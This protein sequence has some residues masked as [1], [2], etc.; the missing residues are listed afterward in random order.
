MAVNFILLAACCYLLR[1]CFIAAKS[2]L[3][4][5]SPVRVSI[6]LYMICGDLQIIFGFFAVSTIAISVAASKLYQEFPLSAH[7]PPRYFMRACLATF[8]YFPAGNILSCLRKSSCLL[9]CFLT[10]SATILPPHFL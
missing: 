10:S 8:N 3:L 4:L 1:H 2:R 7:R 6:D 5:I 9:L